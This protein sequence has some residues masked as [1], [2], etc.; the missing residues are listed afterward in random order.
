MSEPWVGSLDREEERDCV[1]ETCICWVD[2]LAVSYIKDRIYRAHLRLES[3]SRS[4]DV[5]SYFFET[6]SPSS[7]IGTSVVLNR[8]LQ[9]ID[10][11]NSLTSTKL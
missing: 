10:A 6:S 2:R 9:V 3:H 8:Q 7:P 5:S 1:V 11:C 4:R